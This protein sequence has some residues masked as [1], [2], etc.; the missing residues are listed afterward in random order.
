[1]LFGNQLEKKFAPKIKGIIARSSMLSGCAMSTV[2][3]KSF[4][5]FSADDL[6]GYLLEK[7]G[8]NYEGSIS[9]TYHKD[10]QLNIECYFS[11]DRGADIYSDLASAVNANSS[12]FGRVDLT[13]QKNKELSTSFGL[14]RNNVTENNIEKEVELLISTVFD[15]LEC[16]E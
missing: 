15:I 12:K 9:I 7:L 3:D 1:M 8:G 11:F 16:I 4:I 2:S 10:G 14:W 13:R 6:N 5:S